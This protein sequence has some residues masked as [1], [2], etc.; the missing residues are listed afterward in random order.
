MR[1]NGP[2]MIIIFWLFIFA[3]T[4]LVGLKWSVI[5]L[6]LLY[7]GAVMVRSKEFKKQ[8][9]QTDFLN[10]K[11]GD[12]IVVCRGGKGGMA[13]D[14]SELY[15]Y[16]IF[17]LLFTGSIFGHVGLVFRDVDNVLKVVDVRLN[18]DSADGSRHFVCTVPEFDQQY[19]GVKYLT[20]RP[21]LTKDESRRLTEAVYDIAPHIGHCQDCFNPFR[22]AATP[23]VSASREEMFRFGKQYGYGCAENIAMIL[24]WAQ[25]DAP[26]QRFVLPHHFTF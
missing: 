24:R 16:H 22:I 6:V 18:L 21:P 8:F 1:L 12:V 10:V 4:R 19:K 7:V 13:S 25:L 14:V 20:S 23:S 26:S 5:I 2:S 3:L 17:G 11:E 15:M 9:P